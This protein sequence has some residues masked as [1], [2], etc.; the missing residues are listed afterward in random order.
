MVSYGT[1][2]AGEKLNA[3]KKRQQSKHTCT[4]FYQF[5][6]EAYLFENAKELSV[7]E[8]PYTA[9]HMDYSDLYV[10]DWEENWTFVMTHET[11]CGPYFIQK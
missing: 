7:K 1:Y 8:L 4:I 9:G 5:A 3:L 10:M 2:V 6:Q 11:D